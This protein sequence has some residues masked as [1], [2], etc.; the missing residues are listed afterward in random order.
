MIIYELKCNKTGKSYINNCRNKVNEEL[1][2]MRIEFD[3][4]NNTEHDRYNP[5]YEILQNNN[6][7]ISIVE[8]ADDLTFKKKLKEHTGE[9]NEVKVKKTQDKEKIKQWRLDNPDKVMEAKQRYYNKHKDRLKDKY[10]KYR[11]E[12]K[13]YFK[14]YLKNYWKEKRDIYNEKNKKKYYENRDAILQAHKENKVICDICNIEMRKSS[15][16]RH[17]KCKSHQQLCST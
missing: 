2:K 17:L 16:S 5:Y 8:E 10:K 15:F 7:T 4:Y 3:G 1:K 6:Y 13:D 12:H 11:E 9:T 14:E